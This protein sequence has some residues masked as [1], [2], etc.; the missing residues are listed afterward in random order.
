MRVLIC[1]VLTL[2]LLLA[3]PAAMAE[4]D[5]KP[6]DAPVGLKILDF[7]LVRPVGF[8]LSLASTGVFMRGCW[9][10]L[11]AAGRYR[12]QLHWASSQ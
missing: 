1:A 7:V 12:Y 5:A 4:S 9:F 6:A 3:A 11:K 10:A 8:V 2:T